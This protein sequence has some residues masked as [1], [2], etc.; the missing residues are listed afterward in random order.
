MVYICSNVIDLIERVKARDTTP[1]RPVLFTDNEEVIADSIKLMQMCWCDNESERP[2][3][4][5][6]RSYLKKHI[7]KGA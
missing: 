3:F 2:T 5:A 4:S 6:I 7:Q 1:C